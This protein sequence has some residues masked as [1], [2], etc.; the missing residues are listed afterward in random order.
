[1]GIIENELKKEEWKLKE[2]EKQVREKLKKAPKGFL[3]ISNSHAKT[4][5][6]HRSA[7]GNNKNGRYIRK[8]EIEL[9]RQ[10]A[11]RDY[12]LQLLEKTKNRLC[13][14]DRFLKE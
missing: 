6:Y 11:Q 10:L 14:I 13:V 12:D 8:G 2:I 9:A 7:D 5:Y 3:R 4:E 1:M